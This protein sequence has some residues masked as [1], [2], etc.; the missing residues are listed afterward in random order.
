MRITDLDTDGLSLLT[1]FLSVSDSYRLAST[2]VG[3]RTLLEPLFAQ[4]DAQTVREFAR[5]IDVRL[6][7]DFCM[8]EYSGSPAPSDSPVDWP[9]STRTKPPAMTLV[10]TQCQTAVFE[11]VPLVAE[12]FY[13]HKERFVSPAGTKLLYARPILHLSDAPNCQGYL[14][15]ALASLPKAVGEAVVW[16]DHPHKTDAWM[17]SAADGPFFTNDGIVYVGVHSLLAATVTT[18]HPRVSLEAIGE[19]F[20]DSS[21]YEPTGRYVFCNIHMKQLRIYIKK[22]AAIRRSEAGRAAPSGD[23][24]TDARLHLPLPDA[25]ETAR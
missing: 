8:R 23:F 19:C 7:P 3:V 15:R 16:A 14:L 11:Q 18:H 10:A 6:E 17:G 12:V 4:W 9:T 21:H 1:A 24:S 20:I 22:P 2:C 13:L 25:S 5:R